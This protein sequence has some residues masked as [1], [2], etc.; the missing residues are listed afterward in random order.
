MAWSRLGIACLLVLP[1]LAVSAC[2]IG[3]SF[4]VR[5]EPWR[6]EEERA[7]L[8]S[9]LVREEPPFVTVR[10]SL[11]GPS[12]C[13]ALRPFKVA[14]ASH[15]SMALEPP[16]LVRCPMVH[17]IDYWAERVVAPAARRHLRAAVVGIRVA[18]SYSCRPMN[19]VDGALL[20]EHGHANAVDISG[21]VLGDGHV[22]MVREAWH[23]PSPE[24][25]FLRAVH[26]GSCRVFTTVL[27]P[28]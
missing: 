13:G 14:A 5:D 21:F 1:L 19:S 20:S 25:S 12:A 4:V 16:A 18:G 3:P 22:V 11:G 17:A 23:T 26:A 10:S 9:G 6:A 15:G 8:A 2:S 27:G 24:R 7:C 28:S